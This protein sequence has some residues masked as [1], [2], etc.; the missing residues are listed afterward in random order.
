MAQYDKNNQYIGQYVV[1]DIY[2]K[3]EFIRQNNQEEKEIFGYVIGHWTSEDEEK[4]GIAPVQ[5]RKL[6]RKENLS[7]KYLNDIDFENEF[8]GIIYDSFYYKDKLSDRATFS[9][10]INERD[11]EIGGWFILE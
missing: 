5:Y 11:M 2:D 3:K 9:L 10:L 7:E 8:I 1:E 6:I 4:E